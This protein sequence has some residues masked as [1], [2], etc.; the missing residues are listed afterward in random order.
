MADEKK[1]RSGET[2]EINR[3]NFRSNPPIEENVLKGKDKK[4][5]SRDKAMNL[6][7]PAIEEKQG[8]EKKA[9]V[10]HEANIGGC[11]EEL[12]AK[13]EEEQGGKPMAEKPEQLGGE[14]KNPGNPEEGGEGEGG[15]E[16]SSEESPEKIQEELMKG[17]EPSVSDKPMSKREEASEEVKAFDPLPDEDLKALARKNH[18]TLSSTM[19]REAIIRKLIKAGV[20]P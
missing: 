7:G 20:K 12:Q 15:S 5:K 17:P 19:N 11:I 1:D 6:Q 13:V 9:S 3:D 8:A 14:A 16:K 18:V 10:W 4:T 2:P